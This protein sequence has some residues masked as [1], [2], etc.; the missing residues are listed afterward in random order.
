[1]S[2]PSY[3]VRK[4]RERET[5]NIGERLLAK[6]IPVVYSEPNRPD[7]EVI[8]QFPDGRKIILKYDEKGNFVEKPF[9]EI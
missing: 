2:F 7:D 8:K 6:G 5:A 3:E 1:M 9:Y 4:K